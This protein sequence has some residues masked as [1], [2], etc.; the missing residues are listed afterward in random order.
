MKSLEEKILKDGRVIN[1]EYLK[2]D[3]FLN[4]QIDPKTVREFAQEVKKQLAL[5]LAMQLQK[6]LVIYLVSL[7]KNLQLMS[8]LMKIT[9]N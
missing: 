9:P 1:N 6:N 4:H 5:R 3:N 8:K 2:V 7:L